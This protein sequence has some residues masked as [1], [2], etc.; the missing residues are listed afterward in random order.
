MPLTTLL[1]KPCVITRREYDL[2]NTDS[3]GDATFDETEVETVCELQQRQRS[4]EGDPGQL[5]KTSWL[6]VLPHGTEISSADTVTVG[7]DD[8]EV[9]GEPWAAE[10]GSRE[11]WH[12]EATVVRTSGR[13]ESLAD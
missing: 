11:M 9:V 7:G 1:N 8:Y 6:L 5:S 12:V 10:Q 4:E 13:G 3:Y 2:D